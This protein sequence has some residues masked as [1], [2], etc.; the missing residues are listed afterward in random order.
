MWY[1]NIVNLPFLLEEK[2]MTNR[3]PFDGL[4]NVVEALAKLLCSYS[5]DQVKMFVDAG[6]FPGNWYCLSA[7]AVNVICS[8]GGYSTEQLEQATAMAK[9]YMD[10]TYRNNSPSANQNPDTPRA[11][12]RKT[13]TEIVDMSSDSVVLEVAKAALNKLESTDKLYLLSSQNLQDH[14]LAARAAVSSLELADM[15]DDVR[16]TINNRT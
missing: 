13:L 6:K 7:D 12:W 3:T 11:K 14:S 10:K 1:I 8:N 15:I 16:E 2:V 9:E 4:R 5:S